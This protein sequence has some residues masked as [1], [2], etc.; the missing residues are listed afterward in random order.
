MSNITDKFVRMVLVVFMMSA[1][2][3]LPAYKERNV[4]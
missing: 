2:G 1:T 4:P 3:Q